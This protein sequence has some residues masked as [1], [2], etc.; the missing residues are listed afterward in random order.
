MTDIISLLNKRADLDTIM[1]RSTW[2]SV[3]VQ[4]VFVPASSLQSRLHRFSR[5]LAVYTHVA[6]YEVQL[7]GSATGLR[8][9]THNFF[10]AT[11]HQVEGR[12]FEDIG[13]MVP[14]EKG[15]FIT[16]AG[17][18]RLVP[19]D[20]QQDTDAYDLVVLDYTP[21][22]VESPQLDQMFFRLNKETML[23]DD[24]DVIA[25]LAYGCPF[26]D[27]KYHIVDD[28]KLGT[29]TRSLTCKPSSQPL[30]LALAQC[31]TLQP[32]NFDPNGLSG[33][34]VFA[35]VLQG[36]E[37]VVKFAGVINRAGAGK[38]HYIKARVVAQLLNK[39]IA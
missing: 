35:S 24:D 7:I 22:S 27:Q 18:M 4:G 36:S 20:L 16:S 23:D 39:A 30:D 37:I 26:I 14:G 2:T 19:P 12:P 6:G 1:G 31:R 17:L 5:N 11:A 28:N 32:M 13:I 34:P 15:S 10:V 8:Y 33:G 21:Q 9:G 25:C 38:I 3:K 29:V